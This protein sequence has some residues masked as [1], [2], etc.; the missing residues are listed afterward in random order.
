MLE[1]TGRFAEAEPLMCR[2]L[3]I[4]DATFGNEHPSVAIRLSNLA[5]L[6]RATNRL[7]EAEPLMGR[8]LA[9]RE[10]TLGEDHPDTAI[11]L[12]NL[13]SLL[14]DTNRLAEAEPLM[15]RAVNILLKFGRDSG[16]QHPN[17]LAS[18]NNYASLRMAMGDTQAQAKEKALALLTPFG[19]SI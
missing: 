6:Y 7:A 1:A 19:M 12:N 8:A 10:V 3:A 14:Q 16:H 4:D 9:I 11:A 2:S 18:L 5:E 15:R 17:F 13:A